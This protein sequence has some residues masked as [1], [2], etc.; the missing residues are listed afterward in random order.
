MTCSDQLVHG[1]Y[2]L[3]LN[4]KWSWRVFITEDSKTKNRES[5]V[6]GVREVKEKEKEKKEQKQ[7]KRKE[8]GKKKERKVRK[9][10]KKRRK[11]TKE[12]EK[13]KAL[14]VLALS[15]RVS[16]AVVL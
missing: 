11:K 9:K 14:A 4:S 1:S 5:I 6:G 2:L 10:R 12:K 15:S 7:K 8:K 3:R 16:G 13:V